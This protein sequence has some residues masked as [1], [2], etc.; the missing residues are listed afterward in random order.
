MDTFGCCSSYAECSDKKIC[1]YAEDPDYTG[2]KYRVNLEAGR[3]FY[4]VNAG[5]VVAAVPDVDAHTEVEVAE[6]DK[7]VFRHCMTRLFAIYSRRKDQYSQTLTSEQVQKIEAAFDDAGIPYKPCIDDM[8]KCIIDTPSREDPTPANSRVVFEIDGEE[9][10]LLNYNSWLIKRSTAGKITKA[11]DN[12]FIPARVELRGKYAN[13]NTVDLP[14]Y[15]TK[16]VQRPMDPEKVQ[17]INA[18]AP[19]EHR[20]AQKN[21][22]ATQ[23]SIFEI[24]AKQLLSEI[25]DTSAEIQKINAPVPAA[26]QID[27]EIPAELITRGQSIV[28]AD[29]KYCGAYLGELIKYRSMPMNYKFAHVRIIKMLRNPRQDAIFNPMAEVK[30]EPFTIGTEQPFRLENVRFV[31]LVA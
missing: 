1:L 20:E 9:Y 24:Q 18:A 10:H 6:T 17:K 26:A 3:I 8:S 16:P 28:I 15:T 31:F 11:F 2:C 29:D 30:R 22:P 19:A 7:S 25:Q 5:K 23:V 14:T 12:H 13:V 21:K 4:G 27:Y